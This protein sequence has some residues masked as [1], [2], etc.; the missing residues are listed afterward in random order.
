MCGRYLK[1]LNAETDTKIQ[2]SS[3]ELNKSVA[4]HK[5]PLFSLNFCFE[6]NILHKLSFT[7][8]GNIFICNYVN[9][10]YFKFSSVL[11]SN[12][13]NINRY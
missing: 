11:I 4:K 10:A 5:I 1:R 12:M 6:K 8:T 9:K 7:L 3:I 13:A 2:L